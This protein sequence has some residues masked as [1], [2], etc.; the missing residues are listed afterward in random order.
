MKQVV[1]LLIALYLAPGVALSQT[2]VMKGFAD[3][4]FQKTD[5]SDDGGSFAIG[6]YDHFITS[7]LSENVTFLGETVFEYDAGWLIDVERV[8]IRYAFSDQFS[9]SAGKF[10][11]ALGYW[12]RAYH[13][14][15]LL[16]TSIGRPNFLFFEDEGGILPIHTV[17]VMA[18]GSRIGE[19][20]FGYDVIVGNGIG[21]DP[22]GEND[23]TK[24]VSGYVHIEPVS[25]LTTGISFYRDKVAP[26]VLKSDE[27]TPVPNSVTQ[28][29]L[30]ASLAYNKN[31]VEFL[32]E[33]V[34]V[35]NKDQV[36][37]ASGNT[38]GFYALASYRLKSLTPY[39]KFDYVSFSANEPFF[40]GVD[41]KVFTGGV[42]HDINFLSAVKLEVRISDIN[43]NTSV[44]AMSQ[45]SIAF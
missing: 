25:G 4:T 28:F 1:L 15:S 7:E 8:W 42:R 10:H 2:T 21:S 26:G 3:V 44:D 39:V 20:N 5:D 33:Y 31:N 30:G 16:H 35:R 6:Q 29:L 41:T 34:H 12:N 36:T 45:F 18:S 32:S 17:G 27:T 23:K 13:H 19:L 14:G 24:S 38:N 43:S 9:I 11:T 37:D 40:L 22:S